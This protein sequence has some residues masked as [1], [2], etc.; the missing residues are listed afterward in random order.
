ML[1]KKVKVVHIRHDAG[2]Q[3]HRPKIQSESGQVPDCKMHRAD[4]GSA[5]D[6]SRLNLRDQA[7][8]TRWF[9]Q[10]IAVEPSRLETVR[11]ART[12]TALP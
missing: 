2:D 8:V 12:L 9:N 5:L 10:T 11:I 6:R 1:F 3:F 4:R 7:A